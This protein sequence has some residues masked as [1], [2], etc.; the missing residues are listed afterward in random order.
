M[1]VWKDVCGYEGIYQVSNKGRVRSLNRITNYGR[2]CK[3]KVLSQA[4]GG[5]TGEYRSVQLFDLDGNGTRKYVHQLVANA[6]IGAPEEGYQVNHIDENKSNNTA[7]NLEWV[8]ASQNVNYGT[9]CERDAAHKNKP[10]IQMLNDGTIVGKYKSATFAQ[11]K[12]GI[13]RTHISACCLGKAETAGGYLWRF[14]T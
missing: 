5:R 14:A 2:R 3:G 13:W 7:D 10:V 11:Q 12:T 6:F 9:R 4:P 8:T 1:E